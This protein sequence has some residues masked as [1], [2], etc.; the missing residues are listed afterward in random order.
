MVATAPAITSCSFSHPI[1]A[2]ML[3]AGF[4]QRAI[5]IGYSSLALAR[6]PVRAKRLP[7]VLVLLILFPENREFLAFDPFGCISRHRNGIGD[8]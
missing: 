6:V 7:N 4:A 3:C 8:T 1:T 5:A 2:E